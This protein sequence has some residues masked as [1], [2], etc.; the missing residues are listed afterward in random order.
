MARLKGSR[1]ARSKFWS[2]QGEFQG[3]RYESGYEKKFLEMC[4]RMGVRVER[5]QD[6]V[7]YKDSTGKAHRYNPDF[8]LPE[9]G[10]TVEVK[11][12]W[13]FRDNHGFVREKFMAATEHYRGRY[14]LVTEKE[15]KSDYVSN[16]LA[17]LQDGY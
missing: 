7:A 13:A 6:Q 5:C 15:L 2:V 16:M 8:R 12:S 3:V 11:G 1:S 9:F 10:F 14:A 4:F 17:R